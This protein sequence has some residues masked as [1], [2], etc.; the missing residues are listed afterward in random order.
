MTSALKKQFKLEKVFLAEYMLRA[1]SAE[2]GYFSLIKF[3]R[4][5]RDKFLALYYL[6]FKH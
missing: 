6:I 3:E 4:I 2:T 5:L 1:S